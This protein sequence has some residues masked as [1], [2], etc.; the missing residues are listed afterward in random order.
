MYFNICWIGKRLFKVIVIITFLS[1]GVGQAWGA[2]KILTDSQGTVVTMDD[3]SPAVQPGDTIIISASRTLPIK[4]DSI[5]GTSE[6]WITVTN[7][8][9]ATVT[10]EDDGGATTYY[11]GLHLRDCRYIKVIGNNYA[12]KTYGIRFTGAY[13]GVD[14]IDTRDY[15]LAYLEVDNVTVDAGI[16][17][18]ND[19][20]TQS[21]TI[22]N[23]SIHH[24]YIHDIAHEGTYIGHSGS[25]DYPQYDG[26]KIYSLIVKNCGWDG[27]QLSQT[28][29]FS[30]EI[31]DNTIIN[32]GTARVDNQCN[33][34]NLGAEHTGISIYRNYIHSVSGIDYDGDGIYI[35]FGST[36]ID[37]HDNVVWSTFG[38]GIANSSSSSTNK[39][40]N[41]TVISAGAKGINSSLSS[42]VIMYNLLI[43]SG[44]VGCT[45]SSG[46][47]SSSNYNRTSASIAGEYFTNANNGDFSLTKNSPARNRGNISGY[48][49]T[50]YNSNTR[51]FSDNIPDTGAFEYHDG[52]SLLP[53][54][55]LRIIK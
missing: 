3:W 40:R 5:V 33:G 29:G 6:N 22:K 39:I 20:W 50:D 35:P 17:Q 47:C 44:S 25:G 1:L 49:I 21:T 30:N 51:P 48:S 15:E 8:T 53:V 43:S 16:V 18:N 12:G 24:L 38:D 54:Q 46:D 23:V 36:Y 28:T 31:Y 26:I 37:V 10:I 4:F 2:T 14:M 42:P 45:S 34:I 7:P 9:D 11:A 52:N 13:R 55:D 41:N 27:I 32:V 19:S